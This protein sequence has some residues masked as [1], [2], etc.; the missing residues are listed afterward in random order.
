MLRIPILEPS[1]IVTQT[2]LSGA[3]IIRAPLNGAG[4]GAFGC[5]GFTVMNSTETPTDHWRLTAG[6][7]L[8]EDSPYP[9]FQRTPSANAVWDGYG[10][11]HPPQ[12]G[13]WIAGY[14]K[15]GRWWIPE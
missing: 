15:S 5:V 2:P 12:R 6:N 3:D 10:N 13:C 8:F 11:I 4:L 7:A 14:G 1:T 9:G